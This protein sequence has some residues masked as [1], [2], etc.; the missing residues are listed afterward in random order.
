VKAAQRPSAPVISRDFWRG[1]YW[2]PPD[3]VLAAAGAEAERAVGR[4]RLIVVALLAITP[5]IEM[6]RRGTDVLHQ[7]GAGVALVGLLIA[8]LVHLGLRRADGYRAW[9]PFATSALD[10]TLVSLAL[11]A[12]AKAASPEAALNSKATFDIYY[13]AIVAASLRYDRRACV[14]AGILSIAEYIAL[15]A[16]AVPRQGHDLRYGPVLAGDQVARVLMLV[17]VT[18]L[19]AEIVRRA[20]RLQYMSTRDR[21]TGLVNRGFFDNQA[22]EEME[23]AR[24]YGRPMS[25]AMLDV[26]FFKKFNDSYGH[27]TGDAVLQLVAATL[28]EGVRTNDLAARYGGEEFVLLLPETD[29]AGAH[30]ELERLRHAVEHA[31]VSLPERDGPRGVTVST[32]I[33]TFPGDGDD[34]ARLLLRADER[35]YAAKQG[36]RN[37]VVSE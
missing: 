36:G 18:G 25:V 29:R 23:R 14:A 7:L 8:T 5:A 37:R 33:A 9:T 1:S 13:L 16:W 28:G 21:L 30:A 19:S 35:L 2:A 4:A 26:D 32:G 6:A 24:R 17:A 22:E 11:W 3:T 27:D 10:V 31:E 15:A 34:A 20:G 12:Y